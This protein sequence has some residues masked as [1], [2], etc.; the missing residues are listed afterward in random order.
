MGVAEDDDLAGVA[1]Q[2]T[3]R[4]RP[5][6]LVAVRDVDRHAVDRHRSRTRQHRVVRV[7]DVAAD[8]FDRRDPSELAKD[9][10][11]ADVAGVQNPR[12]AV[13]RA[14]N[15]RPYEPVRVGDETDDGRRG[16]GTAAVV[17]VTPRW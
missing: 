9:R 5:A 2:D 10:T 7:V 15:R 12:D 6:K 13:E 3:L 11:A 16:H 14:G 17:S 1:R 4:G 8:R